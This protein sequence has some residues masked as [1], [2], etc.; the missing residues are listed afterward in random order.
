MDP[1]PYRTFQPHALAAEQARWNSLQNNV[2]IYIAKM[3]YE[4]FLLWFFISSKCEEF[5]F[6]IS[7]KNDESLNVRAEG[8]FN[9]KKDI[10]KHFD[11]P[12]TYLVINPAH[13]LLFILSF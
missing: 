3:I 1:S 11:S 6:C 9:S 2:L 5:R 7:W 10:I 13:L 4:L 8:N 12:K